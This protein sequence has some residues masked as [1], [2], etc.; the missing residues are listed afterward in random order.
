MTYN[1]IINMGRHSTLCCTPAK[2]FLQYVIKVPGSC[3]HKGFELTCPSSDQM[4]SFIPVSD[5]VCESDNRFLANG[6]PV[7]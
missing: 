1:A 5:P 4:A 6:L 3:L 7:C 2:G